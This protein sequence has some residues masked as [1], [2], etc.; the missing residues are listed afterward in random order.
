[1]VPDLFAPVVAWR[2]WEVAETKDGWRLLSVHM[3]DTWPVG[4]P[5]VAACHRDRFLAGASD[6]HACPTFDCHCGIHGVSHPEG[7]RQYFVASWA[8]VEYGMIALT[9]DYVPRAVGRVNLWGRVMVHS[10]G[11]RASLA[12]P[13]HLFLPAKRPDGGEFGAECASMGL[14]DYGVPVEMIDAYTRDEML[15]ALPAA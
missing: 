7:A 15:A 8:D 2:T 3:R 13:Q 6:P 10:D 4:E 12:Y 5:L 14:L 11:F 1:M 9:D